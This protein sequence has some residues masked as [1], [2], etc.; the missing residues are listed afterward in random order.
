MQLPRVY[1]GSGSDDVDLTSIY[2][3]NLRNRVQMDHIVQKLAE[4]SSKSD[5]SRMLSVPSYATL[6]T[7]KK[8]IIE[9]GNQCVLIQK[10]LMQLDWVSS[11]DGSHILTVALGPKVMLY[12]PVSYDI[13]QC[14]AAPSSTSASSG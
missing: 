4:S 8:S 1:T 7:L 13:A 9:Q 6:Q 10:S 11:E 2:D 3:A 5:L 12:A 14:N